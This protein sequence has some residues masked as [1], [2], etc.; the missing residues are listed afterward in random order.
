MLDDPIDKRFVRGLNTGRTLEAKGGNGGEGVEGGGERERGREGWHR[1]THELGEKDKY[2]SGI[3][4]LFGP[5]LEQFERL[6]S[7]WRAA[8]AKKAD[9][10]LR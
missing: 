2:L 10:S 1:K 3:T 4:F 9:E 7:G 8:T 6:R 5:P